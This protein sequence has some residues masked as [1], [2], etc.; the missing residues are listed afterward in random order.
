MACYYCHICGKY[1][2]SKDGCGEYKGDC[3]HEECLAEMEEEDG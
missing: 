3:C 1:G 2:E